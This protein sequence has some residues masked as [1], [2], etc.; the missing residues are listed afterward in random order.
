[1]LDLQTAPENSVM[2]FTTF[3]RCDGCG[4]QALSAAQKEGKTDLLFCLHHRKRH[5]DALILDG[6]TVVDDIVAMENLADNT[7]SINI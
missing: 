1:M 3:D 5:Y 6:W 4:A 2:V 7:R